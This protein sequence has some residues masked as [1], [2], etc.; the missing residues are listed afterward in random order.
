VSTVCLAMLCALSTMTAACILYFNISRGLPDIPRFSTLLLVLF[1]HLLFSHLLFF[2]LSFFLISSLCTIPSNFSSQ[3]KEQ[4]ESLRT[5]NDILHGQ[6]QSLGV[7]VNRLLESRAAAALGDSSVVTTSS[8]S[9]ATA[10]AT[11]SDGGKHYLNDTY[12][13]SYERI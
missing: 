7:Q 1:S 12:V 9:T 2:S 3:G 4:M 8:T 11:S 6:V 5:T 10:A 13:T